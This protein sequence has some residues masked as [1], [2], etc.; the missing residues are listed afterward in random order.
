[1]CPES[2]PHSAIGPDVEIVDRTDPASGPDPTAHGLAQFRD[3]I[4]DADGRSHAVDHVTE[5]D[6]TPVVVGSTRTQLSGT[7]SERIERGM[8]RRLSS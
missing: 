5:A 4:S 8:P 6:G 7:C 3:A 1:M 2:T